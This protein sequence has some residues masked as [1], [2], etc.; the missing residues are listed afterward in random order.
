MGQIN[1]EVFVCIDC[2]TTGLDAQADSVIE[3]AAIRFNAD[4]VFEEFDSLINPNCAI[5]DTSIEFHHITQDMVAGKPLIAEVIPTLLQII[6][7]HVIIGHS[8][9]FDIEC[10]A[11]AADRAGIPH[12]LRQN[13]YIDTMRMA[14][15]YG[16][17]PTNSLE[18][19]RKHFNIGDE[20]MHRAK[21]DVLV[22]MEVF[23]SLAK[24]YKT[25]EQV[26][27]LLSR[28]IHLKNM[29]LGKHKG[30]PMKEVP[31]EYLRWAAHKDFDQDLLYSVRL[32]LKRRKQGNL[33]SQSAS[34]FADL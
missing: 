26:L 27:E 6:G 32:E 15:L 2:E 11:I 20:G 28:P 8:V 19:L 16:D 7:K 23:K 14:R 4:T 12:T 13:H 9:H 1:K 17:S 24:R 30:R 25:T 18:Q 31:L 29:P 33:F 3:V 10:I 34:P 21:S 22:N 5:P